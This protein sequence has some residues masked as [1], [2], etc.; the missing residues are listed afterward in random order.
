MAKIPRHET[1]Q[2][3]KMRILMGIINN[4]EEIM[5]RNQKKF[6]MNW[7]EVIV[8]MTF[9]ST[10]SSPS[11]ELNSELCFSKHSTPSLQSVPDG[12]LPALS[13]GS[14]DGGSSEMF[15]LSLNKLGNYHF[16]FNFCCGCVHE[17]MVAG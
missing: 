16:I 9:H 11:S 2:K 3:K 6:L 17:S 5:A 10:V 15:K 14:E 4:T 13:F 12:F 8:K 7:Q 1:E